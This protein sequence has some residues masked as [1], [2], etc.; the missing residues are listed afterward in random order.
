MD[1]NNRYPHL[2]Q[3][4]PN[5]ADEPSCIAQVDVVA[6]QSEC[7]V[8]VRS[9]HPRYLPFCIRNST[10]DV[11][12]TLCQDHASFDTGVTVPPL[13]SRMMAMPLVESSL[14]LLY[15]PVLSVWQPLLISIDLFS[16]LPSPLQEI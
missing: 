2:Y 6:L 14:P 1:I 16:R 3:K 5:P 4:P 11:M 13:T 10:L 12:I 8:Y 7:L 9:I 15:L